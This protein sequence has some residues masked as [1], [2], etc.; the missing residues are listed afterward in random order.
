MGFTGLNSAVLSQRIRIMTATATAPKRS[1][2]PKITQTKLLID[3][4]WVDPNDGKS[5][6]TVNPATGEPI[7]TV[8][9]AGVKDVDRAVKA[10][11]KALESGP[12][13]KMDAAERGKLIFKLADL[14][15]K[16]KEEL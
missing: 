11:R 12:W 2:T 16:H 3:G 6:Q 14:I 9:E 1:A 10:A 4:Q 7:A 13:S 15:E 5:F 8:A